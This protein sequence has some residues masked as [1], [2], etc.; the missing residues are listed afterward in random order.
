M[1]HSVRQHLRL[2]IDAYDVLI[3]KFI[4]AYEEIV[5]R[6]ADEIAGV[7][8]GRVLDLGAGTGALAEAILTRSPGATVYLLD[9]DAEMLAQARVRLKRFGRRARFLQQ[10]FHDP[11]PR[12]DAVAASLALHHVPVME[13]KAELYRQIHEVLALGGVLV[14]A[15]VTMPAAGSHRTRDYAT[16]AAHLVSCGINEARAYE[17]F[18]EWAGED[19]YFPVEAELDALARAGF[20]ARCAWR[21]IPNTLLVG[22]KVRVGQSP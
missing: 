18:E 5:K 14:N 3:R 4:P 6:A 13:D 10:S 11:F 12:C 22:R 15:D 2:E 9:V 19:T 1:K 21:N 7:D 17:H 8:A 20:E 16:W